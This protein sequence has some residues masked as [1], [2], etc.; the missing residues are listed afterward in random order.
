MHTNKF[1]SISITLNQSST[2][3][4]DQNNGINESKDW[5]GKLLYPELNTLNILED[6]DVITRKESDL[7]IIHG[8]LC[9]AFLLLMPASFLSGNALK[10]YLKLDNEIIVLDPKQVK[11]PFGEV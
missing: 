1:S 3:L 9:L 11:N 7:R 8:T 6:Q 2:D 4:I 5:L 10:L